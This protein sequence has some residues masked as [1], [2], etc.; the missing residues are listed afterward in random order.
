MGGTG[1][2]GVKKLAS[3]DAQ[4]LKEL[5]DQVLDKCTTLPSGNAKKEWE[6]F[7]EVRSLLEKVRELEKRLT[8]ELPD[9]ADKWPA[10]FK[11]CL[12]NG[13]ITHGITL[14]AL[15][16]EEYGFAAEHDIQEGEQFLGVPLEMMM[17]TVGARKSKLGPLLREDPIMKSMENVVLSMFLIL[18]L[19]AG[20]T[21]F[22]HPY[23]SIL[24]R[25]FNTVLY[26]TVEE[27]QLLTGSSVLDEAL[28]L[29]RSIAR[30]YAYFH[31]IFRTHPLA[32]SL[33]YKDCF[34][35]DLYRTRTWLIHD[36]LPISRIFPT[37]FRGSDE[38][39]RGIFWVEQFL[40][41][42]AGLRTGESS[43]VL[44]DYDTEA[45]HLKCYAVKDF[46]QGD[47]VTIFYGKRSNAEFL[48]HNGFVYADNRHDA[49]DIKL[50]ISKKDPL[51]AAKSRLCEDQDLSLSGTFSLS[52]GPRPVS[53]D[54]STFLRILVLREAVPDTLP[55]DHILTASDGNARDAAAFLATRIELLLRAFPKTAEEYEQIT[56]SVDASAPAKMAASLRL[57]ERKLLGSV[58]EAVRA[59][60]LLRAAS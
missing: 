42:W 13:A 35:Y 23:I 26:F 39:R 38:S 30:Q 6:D 41:G 55:T 4:K 21:S 28:K 51:F 17:T 48:I 43:V 40:P 24:P 12:D 59:C 58:L 49:V 14:Q 47:Q 54:L 3:Q 50:G 33:P 8:P 45:K 18:E 19:C 31:K 27:L 56:T 10:F 20:N 25:S 9:R 36:Q 1:K 5:L 22:W 44:T 11:W 37:D 52:A 34:T 53:Q 16:Q 29:H 7:L 15:P 46:H 57:S 32:K 2:K 60:P